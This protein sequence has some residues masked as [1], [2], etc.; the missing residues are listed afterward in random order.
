MPS[1]KRRR[2]V[3]F[4]PDGDDDTSTREVKS[5]SNDAS[6]AEE[7]ANFGVWDTF[8]EEYHEVLEQLPLT[9]QRAFALIRELDDQ[10]QSNNTALVDYLRQYLQARTDHSLNGR[11]SE[12]NGSLSP[13]SSKVLI[14][15]VAAITEENS[16][17]A[18]ERVNIAQSAYDSIDRQ[19]CLLDQSIE[20]VETII[21]LASHPDPQSRRI[22]SYTVT[23]RWLRPQTEPLSQPLDHLSGTHEPPTIEL[24]ITDRSHGRTNI[25]S[26]QNNRKGKKKKKNVHGQRVSQKPEIS[27]V[28]DAS[29]R[30]NEPLYCYCNNVSYGAM[31]QCENSPEC[32]HDWFHYDC[33]GL[34][35]APKGKWFCPTCKPGMK[36]ASRKAQ[37]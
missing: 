8:R 13:S 32:P 20:E 17:A 1:R 21:V 36:G 2:S 18:Q 30:P 28:G 12:A 26:V 6:P 16:R 7:K 37:M 10:A 25:A 34:K 14:S 22:L 24:S 9:L 4:A 35:K 23:G 27:T 33:I 3:A 19:I 15:R 5:P 31:V 11:E 29:V